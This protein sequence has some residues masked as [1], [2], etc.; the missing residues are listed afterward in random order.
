[1]RFA[2]KQKLASASGTIIVLPGIAAWAT[3]ALQTAEKDGRTDELVAMLRPLRGRLAARQPAPETASASAALSEILMLPRGIKAHQRDSILTATET[4]ANTSNQKI[5]ADI[6]GI[7]KQRDIFRH[8]PGAQDHALVEQPFDRFGKGAPVNE[9][10]MSLSKEMSKTPAAGLPPGVARKIA[11]PVRKQIDATTVDLH[12]AL[13]DTRAG[14]GAVHMR[15]RQITI[16]AMIW[17]IRDP[18]RTTANSR[19]VET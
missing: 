14:S 15:A 5:K 11:A 1:M 13:E 9:R 6:A 19:G 2:I 16:A 10:I 18:V 17:A 3:D 4:D 12:R 7:G 8:L